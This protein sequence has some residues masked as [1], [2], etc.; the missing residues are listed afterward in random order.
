MSD[1]RKQFDQF[2][3]Q[4]VLYLAFGDSKNDQNLTI[5]LTKRR[6]TPNARIRFGVNVRTATGDFVDGVDFKAILQLPDGTQEQIAIVPN[7]TDG[8]RC[9]LNRD[10]VSYTHL[11]LPTILLV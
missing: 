5:D 7:G 1:H 11:T 4:L 9:E 10:S 3:R 6:F 8:Y 2:W